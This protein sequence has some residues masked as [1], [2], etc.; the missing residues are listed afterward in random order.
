MIGTDSHCG[1]DIGQMGLRL[2]WKSDLY[3]VMLQ[4]S[5]ITAFHISINWSVQSEMKLIPKWEILYIF[6]FAKLYKTRYTYLKIKLSFC[7]SNY[8]QCHEDVWE[9]KA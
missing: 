1:A 6:F 3:C 5:V 7:L 4:M 9:V 8:A 2:N